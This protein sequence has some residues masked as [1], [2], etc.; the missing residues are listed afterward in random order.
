VY[1]QDAVDL[2]C[3]PQFRRLETNQSVSGYFHSM[4]QFS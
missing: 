1:W 3:M 4:L 2:A